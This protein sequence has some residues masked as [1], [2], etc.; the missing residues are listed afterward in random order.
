VPARIPR[1]R[2]IFPIRSGRDSVSS[3]ASSPFG[4]DDPFVGSFLFP[5]TNGGAE[6]HKAFRARSNRGRPLLACITRNGELP[7]RTR[8]WQA[9]LGDVLP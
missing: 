4:M 3:S 1:R 6:P 5:S 9:S 8:S 7:S 2:G